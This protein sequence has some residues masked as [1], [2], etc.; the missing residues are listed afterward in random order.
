MQQMRTKSF[1]V[2]LHVKRRFGRLNLRGQE[3]IISQGNTLW[4]SYLNI[5]ISGY[6]PVDEFCDKGNEPSCFKKT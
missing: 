4:E 6:S 2:K 5:S 1:F 3:I